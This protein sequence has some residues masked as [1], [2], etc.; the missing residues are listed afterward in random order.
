MT[1]DTFDEDPSA[2]TRDFAV[3][4]FVTW[5]NHVLLHWHVK[6][7]RWLPP[8]GHIEPHEIPDDAAR[9]EVWEETGVRALLLDTPSVPTDLPLPGEPRPLCR[10]A[11]VLLTAI[12]RSHQHIDL[13]YFATGCPAEPR[14][15][16]GWFGP[17][18]LPALSLTAEIAAWCD[19]VLTPDDDTSAASAPGTRP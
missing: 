12:S 17:S 7:A 6:L 19:A 18:D 14:D 1:H 15:G 2:I 4:I 13:V 11:G 9:R 5:E 16:V 10:P 8:G 3:A